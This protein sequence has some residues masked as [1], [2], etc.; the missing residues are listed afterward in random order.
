MSGKG[1]HT[2]Q[3]IAVVVFACFFSALVSTS[4]MPTQKYSQVHAVLVSYSIV[5][6]VGIVA[7]VLAYCQSSK[8]THR[9]PSIISDEST[10]SSSRQPIANKPSKNYK[11]SYVQ[12]SGMVLFLIFLVSFDVLSIIDNVECFPTFWKLNC[13]FMTPLLWVIMLVLRLMYVG[14]QVLQTLSIAPR[15]RNGNVRGINSG[16]HLVNV[17]VNVS[18][19]IHNI[20]FESQVVF[21]GEHGPSDDELVC[22]ELVNSSMPLIRTIEDE[23]CLTHSTHL[24]EFC[25]FA[26]PICSP[27][28]TEYF[29]LASAVIFGQWTV[30]AE[31]EAEEQNRQVS[32]QSNDGAMERDQQREF[33][34]SPDF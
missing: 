11:S 5:M 9:N 2:V 30:L 12:I 1:D 20:L 27:M 8:P 7:T 26:E 28:V 29:F 4:W 24:A 31:A 16:A 18:L 13:D 3:H 19:I 6:I 14:A 33:Q 23:K 22:P 17:A 10:D 15:L 34:V 25:K 21:Q 32:H